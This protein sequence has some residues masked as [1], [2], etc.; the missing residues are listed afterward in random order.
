[1]LVALLTVAWVTTTIL[2]DPVAV[3]LPAA[4]G[5]ALAAL[6]GHPSIDRVE[7]LGEL[8][9]TKHLE[10]LASLPSL[11]T[12]RIAST[13]KKIS[14]EHLKVISG[15]KTLEIFHIPHL[16]GYLPNTSDITDEGMAHLQKM[17]QLRELHLVTS[18]ISDKGLTRLAMLSNLRSLHIRAARPQDFSPKP[19]LGDGGVAQL[20][21]LSKLE[22]LRL[23]NV[24][25]TDAGVE[26]LTT[27]S[28]LR[29]LH[30]TWNK[31]S[32]KG[33]EKL[34]SFTKLRTLAIG[35]MGGKHGRYD[36]RTSNSEAVAECSGSSHIFIF[37]RAAGPIAN[38]R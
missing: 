2:G 18:R 23:E 12:L 22:S 35:S 26:Q 27:L 30:F 29:D 21:G 25:L 10:Q 17:T 16:E 38:Y 24:R 37:P 19:S 14:D 6:K 11:R 36:E 31:I 9:S 34:K 1:V 7:C 5:E 33:I 13:G 3:T 4:C 20:G 15:I 8:L 28:E 32:D